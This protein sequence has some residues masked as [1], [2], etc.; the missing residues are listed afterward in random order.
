M[1]LI[2]IKKHL[3][4]FSFLLVVTLFITTTAGC[5]GTEVEV[6]APCG[7]PPPIDRRPTLAAQNEPQA[8]HEQQAQQMQQD[9]LDAPTSPAEQEAPAAQAPELSPDPAPTSGGGNHH[10]LTRLSGMILIAAFTNVMER[11]AEFAWDYITASGM[12]IVAHNEDKHMCMHFIMIMDAAGCCPLTIRIK[13]GDNLCP[14][15]YPEGNPQIEVHGLFRPF[16]RDGRIVYHY[17]A[18]ERLIVL[19]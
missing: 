16:E 8:Q 6:A 18:V 13:H 12:Y 14:D 3:S 19:D 4:K 7:T 10:D 15:D 17:L 1:I 2:A 5:S 11:P 9:N